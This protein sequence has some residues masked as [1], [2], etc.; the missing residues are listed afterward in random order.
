MLSKIAQQYLK[1]IAIGD[2]KK[3][4]E[5][6]SDNLIIHSYKEGLFSGPDALRVYLRSTKP[7]K[8]KW[9]IARQVSPRMVI[10]KGIHRG[11]FFT[12]ISIKVIFQFE[13][14]GKIGHIAIVKLL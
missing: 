1:H 14:D 5:L 2:Y 10:V 11:W 7:F 13:D 4:A 6:C 8:G 9:C 12:T 3:C